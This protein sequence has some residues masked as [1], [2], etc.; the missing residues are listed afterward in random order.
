MDEAATYH[1][2]ETKWRIGGF[3]AVEAANLNEA[4]A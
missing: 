2:L 1:S 3:S 4:L